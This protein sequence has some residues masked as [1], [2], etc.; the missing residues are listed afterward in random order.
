[1]VAVVSHKK[2]RSNDRSPH[3]AN[4]SITLG[5]REDGVDERKEAITTKDNV[6]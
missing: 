2:A 4:E 1:V 3:R 5:I 6:I